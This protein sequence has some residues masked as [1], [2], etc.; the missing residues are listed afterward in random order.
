MHELSPGELVVVHANALAKRH[1]SEEE[2]WTERDQ[3]ALVV[4]KSYRWHEHDDIGS[5]PGFDDWYLVLFSNDCK[6]YYVSDVM[7]SCLKHVSS[8][9]QLV[10]RPRG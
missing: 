1:F 9:K 7:M 6:L 5:L 2:H 3:Y 4:M 10:R 8:P